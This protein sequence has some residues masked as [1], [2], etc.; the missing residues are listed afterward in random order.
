MIRTQIYLNASQKA[1]MEKIAKKNNKSLA[2]LIRSAINTF[3]KLSKK[4]FSD[5][6]L[7]ETF[8]IWKDKKEKG[9]AYT[10]RLRE[11]WNK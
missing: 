8:G 5:T 6:I 3:L 9:T 1:A 7:N 10:R 2:E 11:E 4:E